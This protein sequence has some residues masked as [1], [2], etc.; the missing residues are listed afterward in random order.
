MTHPQVKLLASIFVTFFKMSPTSFGGGYAMIPAMEREIVSR[1][2]WLGAKE[3]ADMFAV[4]GSVPGAVAVNAAT[5]IGY[6][7]AG[8]LG[9]V[10][11][12]L[13]MFLPTFCIVIGLS[14]CYALLKDNP[15]IEAAFLSI[16]AT[17]VALIVYAAIKIGKTAIVDYVTAS[18]AVVAVVLMFFFGHS[19]HPVWLLAAGA[20]SGVV[21]VLVQARCGKTL[22]HKDDEQVYDY[23]I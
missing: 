17:V 7:I 5:M 13:G 4:A 12:L 11:A 10:A 23:S 2:G 15:K 20:F 19:L 1:Q 3:I 21:I 9:A 16:R 6:R 14:A 8:V 18:L 22:Q